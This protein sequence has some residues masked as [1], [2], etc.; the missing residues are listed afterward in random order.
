MNTLRTLFLDELADIYDAEQ[1]MVRALPKMAKAATCSDLKEAILSHLKETEGH[2]TKLERVFKAFGEKAKGKKCE[3]TVG[4]L[5]EADEIAADFKGLPAINAALIGAAQKVEHYEIA[6][7]G[8]LH[9]WAGMLGNREAAGILQGILEEEKEAD[10]SLTVL[11]R[12]KSNKEALGESEQ[13]DSQ[14][15]ATGKR[16]ASLRRGVRPTTSN[17]SPVALQAGHGIPTINTST[18]HAAS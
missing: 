5:E 7:Y 15:G 13:R 17:H 16:A 18:N 4:L 8:C 10:E 12:E 14:P 3:A 6:S 9:E 1:R 11:A 2:V